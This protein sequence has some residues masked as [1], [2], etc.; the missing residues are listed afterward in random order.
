MITEMFQLASTVKGV[1]H[2]TPLRDIRKD[3]LAAGLRTLG[4]SD[5]SHGPDDSKFEASALSKSFPP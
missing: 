1:R 3:R 4:V 2:V 5:S